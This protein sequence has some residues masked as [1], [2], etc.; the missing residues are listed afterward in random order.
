MAEETLYDSEAMRRFAGIELGDDRIPDEITILN[1]RH[2]LERHGLTEAIFAEVNAH[3]AD[4]G[5]TLR[6][7]TLVDATI[8]DAPS[9]TKNGAGARDPEMSSRKKGNDWSSLPEIAKPP[10]MWP[11]H[12]GIGARRQSGT[13]RQRSTRPLWRSQGLLIRRSSTWFALIN[14]QRIDFI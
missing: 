8:I 12:R 7:G 4:K 14:V 5:I 10:Q 1:F 6:S 13:S 11:R 3:L 2:L 9:S